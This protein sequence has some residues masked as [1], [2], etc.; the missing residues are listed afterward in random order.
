M[1]LLYRGH[2]IKEYPLECSIKLIKDV[3][4]TRVYQYAGVLITP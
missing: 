1:K 4:A 2:L 3:V